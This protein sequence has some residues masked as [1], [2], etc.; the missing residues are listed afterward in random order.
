MHFFPLKTSK[1]PSSSGCED[2]KILSSQWI[3]LEWQ[4]STPVSS[5]AF[6]K[7]AHTSHSHA[8]GTSPVKQKSNFFIRGLGCTTAF[9]AGHCWTQACSCTLKLLWFRS[10]A[11]FSFQQIFCCLGSYHYQ[12]ALSI[13]P[14][15]QQGFLL[16]LSRGTT[17]P[18]FMSSVDTSTCIFALI[19]SKVHW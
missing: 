3:L 6:V 17:C 10:Y 14:Y 13:L 9:S 1:G 12:C 2:S 19:H 4:P 16:L 11:I 15:R 7:P 18:Y 5:G 8:L